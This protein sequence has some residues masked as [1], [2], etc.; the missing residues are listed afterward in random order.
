MERTEEPTKD[1]RQSEQPVRK[2]RD[3]LDALESILIEQYEAAR[4][5]TWPRLAAILWERTG[6]DWPAKHVFPALN[7]LNR[8][9]KKMVSACV[10]DRHKLPASG[11]FTN[12]IELAL[13]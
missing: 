5:I 10:V 12:A 6:I 13:L 1:A 7:K 3:L 11:V 4:T 9:C 8:E 2:R